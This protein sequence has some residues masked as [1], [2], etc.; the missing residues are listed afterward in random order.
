MFWAN[1]LLAV[2]VLVFSDQIQQWFGYRVSFWGASWIAPVLGTVIYLYGGRP[3]LTG[4]LDEVRQR[5]PGMMLLITLGITVAFAASL[6][7]L[8][9]VLNL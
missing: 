2:P 1:L 4:A 7:S 3:F 9:S 6:L 8:T 5:R